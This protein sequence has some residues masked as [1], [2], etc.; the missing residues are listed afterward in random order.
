VAWTPILPVRP[1]SAYSFPSDEPHNTER[2]AG[3]PRAP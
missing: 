1:G 3:L 2:A